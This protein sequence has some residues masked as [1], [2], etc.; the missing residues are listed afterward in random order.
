M[1]KTI[2]II[3]L[4]L[5]IPTITA[6]GTWQMWNFRLRMPDYD[7]DGCIGMSDFVK[8]VDH[9]DSCSYGNGRYQKRF[10]LNRDGCINDRDVDIFKGF[11]EV[12]R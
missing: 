1:K 7:R 12:C 5:F 4:L 3:L 2:F 11:Y 9:M 8:M 6:Y 10:D